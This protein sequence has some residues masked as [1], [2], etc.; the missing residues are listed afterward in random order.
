ME[1]TKVI[2]VIVL[3]LVQAIK[4]AELVENRWLP[5]VA[6][7]IGLIIGTIFAMLDQPMSW[8]HIVR[9]FLYGATASGLYDAGKSLLDSDKAIG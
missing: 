8:E 4:K 7:S 3:I 2:P 6:L 1:I 9:G 5:F